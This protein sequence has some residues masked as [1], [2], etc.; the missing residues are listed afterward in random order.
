[1]QD[2]F[3]DFIR[4]NREQFDTFEPDRTV[5]KKVEKNMRFRHPVN[6]RKLLYRIAGMAAIF[7]LAFM[8][9]TWVLKLSG[10]E[11]FTLFT[12]LGKS[13]HVSGKLRE[14]E[15][16][17]TGIIKE[18]MQ[19]IQPIIDGCPALKEELQVDFSE[20]D[21]VYA[22]LKNDLKDN[23]SNQEVIQAIID[24]YKLRIKILE[25]MLIELDTDDEVCIPNNEGYAL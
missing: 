14:A 11:N 6:R 2:Q 15:V 25:D 21:Q 13:V 17:Y 10:N 16:Y 23:M 20:L 5:W 18:K 19:E 9:S 1:M 12:G 24:N 22:S 4:E 8:C 7:M 3:E